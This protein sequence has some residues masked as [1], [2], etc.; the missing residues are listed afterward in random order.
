LNIVAEGITRREIKNTEAGEIFIQMNR[1]IKGEDIDNNVDTE[2]IND[3][4]KLTVFIL[5]IRLISGTLSTANINLPTKFIS[6]IKIT[7]DLT[8][9]SY[10]LIE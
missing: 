10:A 2:S 8:K 3:M 1:A 4:D 9:K 7:V 5:E 6:I